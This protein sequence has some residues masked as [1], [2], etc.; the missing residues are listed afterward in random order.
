MAHHTWYYKISNISLLH[1]ISYDDGYDNI[2]NTIGME[3]MC[4]QSII[5]GKGGNGWED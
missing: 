2:M 3:K 1:Y 5:G 4:R